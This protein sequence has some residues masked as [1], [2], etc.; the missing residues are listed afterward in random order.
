VTLI[1]PATIY[2]DCDV[3]IGYD[4]II[5]PNSYLEGATDI[6]ANC[7]IG[8][9]ARLINTEIGDDV[10]IHNVHAT[11]AEVHSG[12]TVGPYVHLRPGAVIGNSAHLGNFVEVKNSNIGV[13][14][15]VSHLTY[16]GDTDM[17]NDVNIGCGVVTVNYDGFKKHRT[18]IEDR[19]FVGCNVNLLA[20]VT[21]GEGAYVAAGSTI[22]QRVPSDALGLARAKQEN[23]LEGAARFRRIHGKR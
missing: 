7:E 2:I 23:K 16:I 11:L 13:N 1:D 4:T 8:P 19:A 21:V 6:G 22:N 5:Y 18:T 20:P 15:K 17:G 9:N 14:S 3:S 10:K 12:A